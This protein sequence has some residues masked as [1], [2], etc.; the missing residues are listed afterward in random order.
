M[1]GRLHGSPTP[2]AKGPDPATFEAIFHPPPDICFC[3]HL[4]LPI[5]PNLERPKEQP[6]RA[7]SRPPPTNPTR[8]NNPRDPGNAPSLARPGSSASG[9]TRRDSVGHPISPDG[10]NSRPP[11]ES[12]KKLDQILQNFYLKAAALILES[13]MSLHYTSSS[14][15]SKWFQI[16]TRDFDDFREELRMWKTCGSF[17]NRPPPLIIEVY[18]D[19][20][21]L[22]T[23]Q[24]LVIID[25][26]GKRWDVAEAL[27]SS[28]SSSSENQSG[29]PARNTD[30]ILERWRIDLKTSAYDNDDFAPVLPTI[31]KKA[32][33]FFRSLY[34]ETR[35][36]PC[37]HFSQHDKQKD[38][39]P[40]LRPRCRIKM[41]ESE[42]RGPDPLKHPLYN[43]SKQVYEEYVFGDLE[44]PVGRLY[45]SIAYRKDLNFRIDD[46]E[47]LLSS[48]FMG[49]DESL[50]KPSLPQSLGNRQH[51]AFREIG[52]QG[53][54]K[55]PPLP[56][57]TY[58][59]LST[60][61]GAGPIGTSPI[62]ALNAVRAPG[63][64]T[65]SPPQ[66]LPTNPEPEPPHSVPITS[67][68]GAGNRFST[69]PTGGHNPVDPPY[70][71][72]ELFDGRNASIPAWTS[73]PHQL[74]S[75]PEPRDT[76]CTS[77]LPR[78]A[79]TSRYSSSFTHRRGR[80][81][82]SGPNK[83]LDDDQL[84]SGRQ[85]VSSSVIQPGSGLLADAGAVASSGSFQT[86]DD[87]ISE[88]LKVLENKKNLKSFESSKRAESATNRTVAQL[89]RFHLMKE[90]NHQLTESMTSSSIQM[91]RSSST[92]S[93][94]L[95]SVPGMVAPASVSSSDSPVK[96]LSPHT[97]H[98]PAIP[99]RLSE[100]SIISYPRDHRGAHEAAGSTR[101]AAPAEP[102]RE[103]T[104]TQER[105]AA[106]D[107]PLSPRVG[108]HARRPSSVVQEP[109]AI[110]TDD[111]DADMPFA[112]RSISLGTDRE[113]LAALSALRGMPLGVEDDDD[114]DD[115]D[116]EP[117]TAPRGIGTDA[118]D[119]VASPSE[120]MPPSSGDGKS[121]SSLLP[122]SS[123]S[124]FGRR[125]YMGM[126]HAIAGRGQT[127]PN[128][129]RGSYMGA[130]GVNRHSRVEN[131]DDEPLLFVMS[132]MDAHS[133][134]SLEE[135]RGGG[136]AGSGPGADR[137]AARRGW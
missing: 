42:R 59:S 27:A 76:R 53:G 51:S 136:G 98:T 12:V 123:S 87:N 133:R 93:R 101:D 75:C 103:S 29:G 24:S 9:H 44:L 114:D 22:A 130:G 106:I 132:E 2:K 62:S 30:I 11:L 23:S 31:Y 82:F 8:T 102:S 58:G 104:I 25:E 47:K 134:R 117:R 127:P 37:F 63:S 35:I 49:A 54:T 10:A 120:M 107:I 41:S 16:E 50:F 85:S 4:S 45:A 57:Q 119:V 112:H 100:N 77:Q 91:Q 39:Y 6:E 14:K 1:D 90:A 135:G 131:D 92:S 137:N 108:P 113:P 55:R 67:G 26:H 17:D 73:S 56:A 13:R 125:R 46:S 81:S 19:T 65:S 15:M 111:D 89:S 96:P 38:L 86:D 28:G 116:D 66:S 61:H 129:S 74:Q 78:P 115:D 69:A 60:F 48:R 105:V 32:I 95:T 72:R 33:V 128:T 88:F 52:T 124:P 84:S 5:I 118:S 97:P 3:V 71:S 110:S 68:F 36:S 126:A 109:R 80:L 121:P 40:T 34:L 43:S 21:E 7:E 79:S 99:S 83:P 64:D 20:S 122:A 18:L 94:Q 70:R